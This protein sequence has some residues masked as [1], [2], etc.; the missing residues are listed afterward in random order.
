MLVVTAALALSLAYVLRQMTR[1]PVNNPQKF[2]QLGGRSSLVPGQRIVV[3]LGASIVHG[4]VCPNFVDLA[5]TRLPSSAFAFV[6]AGVN[7][8]TSYHVLQRLDRVIACDPDYVIILVGTND[9]ICTLIPEQW[10][11]YRGNKRLP[12]PPTIETYSTNLHQIVRRLRHETHSQ[13]AICSLPV[14]GEDLKAAGNERVRLFN[15]AIRQ[16]CEAEEARYL[17]VYEQEASYLAERQQSN[18]VQGVAFKPVEKE[19]LRYSFLGTIR[20]YLLQQSWDKI[21]SSR[22]MLLKTDTIHGNSIEA[23]IISGNLITFLG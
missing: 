8:D 18:Q 6:N 3:C 17:P 11:M 20:H 5:A 1:L 21:A 4:R 22:G 16:I 23:E 19:I 13:I 10:R 2:R 7:G 15:R 12:S 9:V 14:L